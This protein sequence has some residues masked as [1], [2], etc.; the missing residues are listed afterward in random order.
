M[1]DK[2]IV[3]VYYAPLQSL[4]RSICHGVAPTHGLS[5]RILQYTHRGPLMRYPGRF[6]FRFRIHAP[7]P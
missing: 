2:S 7:L 6:S 3:A 1:V 4:G 5:G